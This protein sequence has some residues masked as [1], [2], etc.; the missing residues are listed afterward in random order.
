[1]GAF[2]PRIFPASGHGTGVQLEAVLSYLVTDQFTI[3]V[4]GRYWAMWTTD[5]QR[6]C[7]DCSAVGSVSP[8]TSFRAA[9]EQVGIFLQAGYKFDGTLFAKN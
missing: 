5:A 2:G 8:P 9:T 4:G 1:L 6:Y 3:G 7:I